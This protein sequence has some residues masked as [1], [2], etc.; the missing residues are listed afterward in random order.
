MGVDMPFEKI[1]RL[2][3]SQKSRLKNLSALVAVNIIIMGLGFVTKVAIANILGKESFG[4]FAYA[5]ALGAFGMVFVRFG[6]DRTL[7][8]DLI[9]YPDKFSRL[10]SGSILLRVTMFLFIIACIAIV[11]THFPQTGD[12]T[13]GIILIAIATT[14]ISLDLQSVYDSWHMMQRH[15]IYNLV[16]KCCYF[17]ILWTVIIITPD[18]LSI[19]IIGYAML[20]AVSLYLVIQYKWAMQKIDFTGLNFNIVNTAISMAKNNL[21]IYAAAIGGLVIGTLNQILLKNISGDEQL[22]DYSAAWQLVSLAM[23]LLM[24][25]SRVGN[26]LM[27]EVTKENATSQRR[28]SFFIKYVSLMFAIAAPIG[29]PMILF[30]EIIL[31]LIYNP[32]YVTAAPVMRILGVYVILYSTGLAAS[33]YIVSCRMD[34]LYLISV[35]IGS[36]TSVALCYMLIPRYFAIGAAL[37]LLISHGIS[38]GIYYIRIINDMHENKSCST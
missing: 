34:K 1:N 23:I 13:L 7:V 15:A 24:Q 17:I 10:V 5:M 26:P 18:L 16:H 25:V 37:S 27:A 3:I 31:S 20:I 2:I 8:R 6:L 29:L 35:I 19:E 14:V 38:I 36:I 11:K 28:K 22:G 4:Q 32:E 12:M 21:L 9:H 30:P 33:Q